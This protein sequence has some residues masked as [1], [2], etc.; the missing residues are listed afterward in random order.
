VPN[1]LLSEIDA[2]T[3]RAHWHL[4]DGGHRCFHLREYT[5]GAGYAVSDTNN[6]ISNLQIGPWHRAGR[7]WPHRGRAIDQVVQEFREAFAATPHF[8][9][10]WLLVPM[11]LSRAKNDPDYD[12]MLV[13]VVSGICTGSDGQW[14]ELLVARASRESA[15]G[16][17]DRPTPEQHAENLRVDEDRVPIPEPRRLAIV[18][19]VLISGSGF[20]GARR[21]LLRRF[22]KAEIVGLFVAR[23]DYS[24]TSDG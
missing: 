24:P 18:D 19:D 7:R 6:L 4:R 23:P 17:T 21:V 3:L 13:Q 11:P 20:V 22:P 8:L 9:R 1:L 2:L 12:D 10:D 15:K 5:P 14:A 16:R